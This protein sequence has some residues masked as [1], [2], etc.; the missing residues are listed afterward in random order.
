M[1]IHFRLVSSL[2]RL[3]QPAPL[4]DRG[5]QLLLP[6][7]ALLGSQPLRP[8]PLQRVH[9]HVERPYT[10]SSPFILM[11]VIYSL[12]LAFKKT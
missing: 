4:L 6:R 8:P 1:K 9:H 10:L 3:Q 12:L 11:G 2:K 7:A 5:L